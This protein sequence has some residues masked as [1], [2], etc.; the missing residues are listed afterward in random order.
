MPPM[1]QPP[2]AA[3]P[4]LFTKNQAAA[5]ACVDPKTIQRS[6][7]TPENAAAGRVRL[8]NAFRDGDG[9]NAPWLIP[10]SDLVAAGLCAAAALAGHGAGTAEQAFDRQR[11][12]RELGRLR[13]ENAAFRASDQ[14]KT[15]LLEDRE[16]ELDRLRKEITKLLEIVASA[17]R[18]VA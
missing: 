15:A 18:S 4:V 3:E 12:A 6:L 10:G 9:P 2:A 11:D 5:L 17:V 1:P 7:P 13:E 16:R 8:P 14:V